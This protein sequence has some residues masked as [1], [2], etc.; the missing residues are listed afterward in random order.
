MLRRLAQNES[1]VA[2]VEF[3]IVLP[4]L[5]T[6]FVGSYVLSDMISCYRKVT[7]TTRALTDLA[8][9]SISP[10]SAPATTTVT[11][12]MS[13]AQLVM[14]PFDTSKAAVQIAQLRVCD[15]SHAYVVWS[16][17]QTGSTTATPTLTAGSVVSVPAGVISSPMVPT[18][19]NACATGVAGT[20]GA[21]LFYGQAA[22]TYTPVIT[23]LQNMG[24][25]M[26]DQI[27][28]SPRLN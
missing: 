23:Y 20:A 2:M 15:T 14:S 1:G 24:S 8:S 21:Y 4:V 27:Y 18:T 10:T 17:A 12:Y 26:A 9:R 3:A 16:Q 22:Y 13:S 11:T 28:M 19:S 25:T 5:I 7:A 6:L